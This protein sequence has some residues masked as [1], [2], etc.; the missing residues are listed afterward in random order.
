M[1]PED[2]LALAGRR[3]IAALLIAREAAGFRLQASQA[4]NETM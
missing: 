2:A 3:R 1:A 4:W